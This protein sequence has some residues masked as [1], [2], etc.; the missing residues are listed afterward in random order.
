MNEVIGYARVSTGG[1][2]LGLQLDAL[3]A[4]GVKRIF[5]DVGSGSLRSRPQLGACLERLRDG[6]TLTVWRLDRLGR[7]L[8]HLLTLLAELSERGVAFRSLTEAIDTTTAAGRLQV[9]LFAALAEFER[10]LGQERTRAGLE[11]ARARGRMGGRPAVVT[12]RKLA[13]ALAMRDRGD[14]TMTQ[15]AEELGVSPASLYR[16]LA[17][18]RQETEAIEATEAAAT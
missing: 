15:V 9:H 18:H 3:Q 17:R 6:D 1:Q 5:P 11:A 12:S 7:S 2:D 14:L 16:R 4:A 10:S 8:R 13:A